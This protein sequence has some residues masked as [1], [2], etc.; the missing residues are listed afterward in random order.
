MPEHEHQYIA[1]V[2]INELPKSLKG[3]ETSLVTSLE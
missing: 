1:I 3:I 2:L